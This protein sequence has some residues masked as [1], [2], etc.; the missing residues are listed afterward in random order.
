MNATAAAS[1]VARRTVVRSLGVTKLSLSGSTR[2]RASF[3]SHCDGAASRGETCG[4]SDMK[5]HTEGCSARLPCSHVIRFS[6]A[7][8]PS[9]PLVARCDG[10]LDSVRF[11]P[12]YRLPPLRCAGKCSNGYSVNVRGAKAHRVR[13]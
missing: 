9:C 6:P 8:G 13:V 1:P 2:Q 3:A 11:P 12:A 4:N 5:L 7:L 10:N